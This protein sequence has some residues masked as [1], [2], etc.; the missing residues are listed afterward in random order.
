MKQLNLDK[1]KKAQS[2]FED[3]RV[4]MKDD[5]EKAGAVQAFEVCYE[6]AWKT[7]KRALELRGQETGSPKDTFRK[8]A[9]EG[10]IKDRELWFEFQQKRNLTVSTYERDNLNSI[11]EIFD[12][13]S[14]ELAAVIKN[15]ED[16]K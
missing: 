2:V 7:I 11:I 10:I 6:L 12:V 8:A 14:R 1:L 5:R 13:F 4:D 16:L 15:I 3:F 9:K